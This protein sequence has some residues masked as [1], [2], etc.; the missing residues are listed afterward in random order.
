MHPR[1][2]GAQPRRPGLVAAAL[3]PANLRGRPGRLD[4]TVA[5]PPG[6]ESLNVVIPWSDD[7]LTTDDGLTLALDGLQGFAEEARQIW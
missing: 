7:T 1:R 5:L 3:A 2:G 6:H 4:V